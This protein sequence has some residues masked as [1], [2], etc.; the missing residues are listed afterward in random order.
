M[1]IGLVGAGRIGF[2]HAT[3]LA[4]LSGVTDVMIADVD[5]ERARVVADK[6]GASAMPTVADLIAARPDGV[7]IAAPTGTHADLI[8]TFATAGLPIFCEKPIALDMDGTR[9]VLDAVKAAGVPLHIGFQRRFDAGIAAVRDAIASGELGWLHTLRSCTS[10][11]TPPPAS[12]IATSGGIF[13]DCAVHDFDTVRWITGR[14]VVEVYATGSN[15]G[16]SFFADADDVDTAVATLTFDDGTLAVCTAT[17][18]NGAGYDVRLEAHGS[19][20]TV[21]AGISER[22]PLVSLDCP[23]PLGQNPYTGFGDRFKAAY[24]AELEAF[25]EL[26]AGKRDSPCTGEDAL[27]ALLVA[28]AAELSRRERRPVRIEELRGNQ[29]RA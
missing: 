10:D 11:P 13:R 5:H 28:E 24:A 22:T 17:R 15:R 3:T 19:V 25:T 2:Q 6:V 12:Y 14:E 1:Q 20:R 8:R 16:E 27:E 18:Y 7:V 29:V 21:A 23:M 4:G 26:V 9:D